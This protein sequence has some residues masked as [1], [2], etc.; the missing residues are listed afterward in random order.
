[1]SQRYFVQRGQFSDCRHYGTD[2]EMVTAA[3]YDALAAAA[4]EA[5]RILANIDGMDTEE[6]EFNDSCCIAID[7][8]EF[9]ASCQGIDDCIADLRKLMEGER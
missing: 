8:H 4:R 7:Q 2:I 6:C 3:D 1:M 5:L 9:D